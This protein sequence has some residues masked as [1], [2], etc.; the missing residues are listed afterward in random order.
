MS[1][2]GSFESPETIAWQYEKAGAFAITAGTA[3]VRIG[4]EIH[5]LD[6]D[7][8][9]VEW[10]SGDLGAAGGRPA[11]VDG[12]VYVGG[13]ELTAIDASTGERRWQREL[14]GDWS[15]PWSPPRR[16]TPSTRGTS[17]R[18]A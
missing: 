3:Y 2:D 10:T 7:D 6:T 17:L 4:T 9:S 15:R 5:A 11:V 13:G 12:T 16:C 14:D 8:G 1:A 18:S